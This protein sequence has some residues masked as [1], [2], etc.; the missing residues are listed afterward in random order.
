M[1]KV[2]NSILFE[3]NNVPA[4]LHKN[5][6]LYNRRATTRTS[7]SICLV[8]SNQVLSKNQYRGFKLHLLVEGVELFD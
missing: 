2:G 3:N 5:L 1:H 7:V 6:F 4:T 8:N